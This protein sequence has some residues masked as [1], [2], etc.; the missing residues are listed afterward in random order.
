MVTVGNRLWL[1]T[2]ATP[3]C[4]SADSVGKSL[5]F[6]VAGRSPS[7]TNRMT[8]C[9]TASG[10]G[11]PQAPS[12]PPASAV[13]KRNRAGCRPRIETDLMPSSFFLIAAA[14][15]KKEAAPAND[16]CVTIRR[17]CHAAAAY[18]VFLVGPL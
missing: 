1:L 8:L 11:A 16:N 18:L 4:C 13:K 6:T 2:K 5:S 10:G 14:T 12:A 3:A 17:P 9:R 15:Y 7:A